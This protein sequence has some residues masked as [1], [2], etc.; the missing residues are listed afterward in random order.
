MRRSGNVKAGGASSRTFSCTSKIAQRLRGD[1]QQRLF[2]MT[3]FG[4]ILIES[5]DEPGAI[6]RRPGDAVLAACGL[7]DTQWTQQRCAS[8]F[9]V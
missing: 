1:D 6:P 8:R 7:A 2:D 9:D 3:R 4:A 5:E